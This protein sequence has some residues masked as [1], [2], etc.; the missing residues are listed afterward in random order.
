MQ[1]WYWGNRSELVAFCSWHSVVLSHRTVVVVSI[2][3]IHMVKQG[4]SMGTRVQFTKLLGMLTEARMRHASV[5]Q[6]VVPN[7]KTPNTPK[8]IP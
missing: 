1:E 7:S 8:H 2:Y 4:F 5:M 6:Q 3:S